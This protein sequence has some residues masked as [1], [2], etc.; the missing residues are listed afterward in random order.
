V[1]SAKALYSA[2]LN[3]SGPNYGNWH[4]I[5]GS[6]Q[7]PLKGV[8]SGTMQLGEEKSVEVYLLDIGALTLQQRS[9]LLSFAAAKF[10]APVYEVEREIA[11]NGFPVRAADVIVSYSLRAFV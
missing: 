2:I 6:M 3:P 1:S 4:S 9:R 5:L 10:G 11:K 7:V 8:A